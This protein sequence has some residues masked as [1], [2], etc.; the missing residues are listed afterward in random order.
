MGV[1]PIPWTAIDRYAERHGVT[2]PDDYDEFVELISA[3]DSAYLEHA[4]KE[5]EARESAAKA[6]ARAR[7]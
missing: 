2:D 5:A 7:R 4:Q 6:K 1:G 3:M